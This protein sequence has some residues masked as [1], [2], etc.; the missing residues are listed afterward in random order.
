MK[1]QECSWLVCIFSS[2][3]AL[4]LPASTTSAAVVTW[5]GTSGVGVWDEPTNW[6]GGNVPGPGDDVVLPDIGLQYQVICVLNPSN[7]ASFTINSLTIEGVSFPTVLN[8]YN[9]G[10]LT[11]LS[12]LDVRPKGYL[13]VFRNG[14]VRAFGPVTVDN[15]GSVSVGTKSESTGTL[16]IDDTM[17]LNNIG[18]DIYGNLVL[19]GTLQGSAL[20]RLF[21]GA[22]L[23]GIG[24]I[25]NLT[26]P[27]YLLF[28]GNPA[29]GGVLTNQ[30]EVRWANA[31]D[32]T[33]S[34]DDLTFTNDGLFLYNGYS[35]LVT[36]T[37]N[38]TSGTSSFVNNGMVQV[39]NYSTGI[40][41]F[42]VPFTNNSSG[43]VY[44][45]NIGFG[46]SFTN[47]A[48]GTL[49]GWGPFD[50][51]GATVNNNGTIDPTFWFSTTTNQMLITGD[52]PLGVSSTSLI[53]IEY[54][55][56]SDDKLVISGAATLGG[57]LDVSLINSYIPLLGHSMEILSAASVS[58]T[59]ATENL[60]TL[61]SGL[62][63]YVHYNSTNVCLE[64]VE[65]GTTFANLSVSLDGSGSGTVTSDP[66]GS[67]CGSTVNWAFV[68]GTSI[69][70]TA[71]PETGSTFVS[72]SGDAD[73]EDGVLT[74]D[75]SI[76]C[77]ATFGLDT[78]GDG[79]ADSI[80]IILGTDP[81]EEDSD[82]DGLSDFDEVNLDGDPT[83]YSVGVDTD[84]TDPDTDG[85]WYY[86]GAES[87]FGSDPLDP[88]SIVSS[89]IRVSAD[90]DGTGANK[91]S[92][93]VPSIS[94]DGRYVI[95]HSWASNL[96]EEDDTNDRNDVFV[97]D[98]L[99]GV[100]TR[101]S[102][103]SLG[104]EANQS[105][106]L[107]AVSADGRYV[108]F[109]S[110]ATNL[111]EGDTNGGA[112]D[113]FLKDTQTGSTT[114]V[115]TD[116]NGVQANS[117]S[118]APVV[119]GDGQYVVF[120]SY[121]DNLVAGD[122]N[123]SLDIF[124]KDTQSGTTIRVSTDSSGV[125]GNSDSEYA[126]I[127]SDGRYIVF[128]SYASNL[129]A[130]DTNDA[131][132]V[133]IKNR[134]TGETT[135]LSTDSDGAEGNDESDLPAVSSDGRYV[136]FE[137]YATNL[138]VGDTNAKS[139]IFLKDTLTGS[140]TRVSTDSNG[141]ES[142]NDSQISDVSSDGRLVVFDS[143]ASN[144]VA[145]DTNGTSDIFLKNTQTGTTTRLSTN[146][147]GSEGNNLSEHPVISSDGSYIGFKSSASN[148]VANDI[149]GFVDMF[150]VS[151]TTVEPDSLI[152]GIP[153]QG[154]Q[155]WFLSPWF[156]YYNTTLAPWLFHAEHGFIYHDPGS[157]NAS[158]F[159][160]DDSMTAWW[161]TNESN[162][163]YIYAF[164]PPADNAGTDIESAWLWYF[165]DS[166]TPR[167]FGV[168]TGPSADGFLFFNP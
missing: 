105:C 61:D 64:V 68:S 76:S 66:A 11:V 12:A 128:E 123:E 13:N 70:L 134:E 20:V 17:T 113:I 97:K 166:K 90:S 107:P 78:D 42:D 115:S 101:V 39:D 77:I 60:P 163:P 9:S 83:S 28:W 144:L 88:G 149:G 143:Y 114:R 55:P 161:W 120:R 155:D 133:F 51:S 40:L 146:S 36:G 72:W 5:T 125:E 99:T 80:E 104:M 31:A 71:T 45:H 93:D 2:I 140:T 98:T 147:S 58:G 158:M 121:A 19:N 4:C 29:L 154:L 41:N 168:V 1:K 136:V 92:Y 81:E 117:G 119:S 54:Y 160:Y 167:S 38:T 132:D 131:T 153:V 152:G 74:M 151:S 3:M 130:G 126:V 32:S 53:E 67:N 87:S 18:A 16:E 86:D 56:G 49:Q 89:I 26:S 24:G 100:T 135:R 157:T 23:T 110:G 102:T 156:R 138:V 21:D 159:V 14:I 27:G 111:V 37:V 65:P 109:E 10:D 124:L 43:T 7:P 95:F 47:E 46:S 145:G 165:E 96:A 106:T 75:G 94:G 50:F 52:F 79:L 44:G 25:I 84:P 112:T 150:R 35:G 103:D 63:W 62:T 48:G 141:L 30:G 82:S 33:I 108:V 116:S 85:D 127:S 137:S 8:V 59:F 69:T 142:N 22:A 162:Y 139:D 57:N 6:S 15:G 118:E 148:L 34:F 91:N 129:V 73:C 164:N 122:T